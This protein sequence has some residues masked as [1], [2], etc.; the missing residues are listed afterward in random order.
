M[1]L[2][3]ILVYLNGASRAPTVLEMAL[4]LAAR[5]DSHVVGLHVVPQVS[6]PAVVPVEVTGEII[7]AE[8]KALE[9]EGASIAEIFK[10]QT[11]GMEARTE[12]RL[13]R[14][15]HFRL[16]NIVDTHGRAADL[17]IAPQSDPDGG[18]YQ[19]ADITEDIMMEAGRPVLVVPKSGTYPTAGSRVLIA[20]NE[21]REAARAAFDALPMLVKAEKVT[22]FTVTE[23]R[24]RQPELPGA[25]IGTALARHGVRCEAASAP[26][27]GRTVSEQLR[28]ALKEHRSD[29][30]VMGGYGHSRFS[31]LIFG[32]ATRF[33]M[34]SMP[35][36]VLFSH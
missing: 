32:G 8:R 26:T 28:T 16:S 7:E 30:L 34:Q 10:K 1:S 5:H 24:G 35:V 14:A 25:E 4:G 36:P 11:A 15:S 31:E 18:I 22:I 23:N 12:W 33:M 17:I 9:A 6:V 19:P 27:D 2:K 13:V 3:T 29:L 21:S 20:W